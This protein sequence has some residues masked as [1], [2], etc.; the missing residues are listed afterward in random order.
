MRGA[1][2]PRLASEHV[3]P[4]TASPAPATCDR[5]N[6]ADDPEAK[7]A[8][9][10]KLDKLQSAKVQDRMAAE[11]GFLS[12][13]AR[14]VAEDNRR[15]QKALAEAQRCIY[16]LKAQCLALRDRVAHGETDSP[17]P[18][19]Q[20]S[21]TSGAA[22]ATLQARVVAELQAIIQRQGQQLAAL[23]RQSS[24]D[25]GLLEAVPEVHASTGPVDPT[26]QSPLSPLSPLVPLSHTSA[27]WNAAVVPQSSSL[28]SISAHLP[29]ASPHSVDQSVERAGDVSRLRKNDTPVLGSHN[30]DVS[31]PGSPSNTCRWVLDK[32][33]TVR[34]PSSPQGS[35]SD[36]QFI[37]APGSDPAA[38]KTSIARPGPSPSSPHHQGWLDCFDDRGRFFGV[39]RQRWCVL[40]GA[41]LVCY[42]SDRALAPALFLPLRCVAAFH[43]LV[44]RRLHRAATD[45]TAFFF[46]F[47]FQLSPTAP[48]TVLLF[49]A[50]DRREWKQW[51]TVAPAHLPSTASGAGRG[52]DGGEL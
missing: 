34:I 39:F 22:P 52:R 51:C 40:D 47:E 15:L 49:R 30:S 48:R 33:V 24:W 14:S 25:E 13:L 29:R 23:S 32:H 43:P 3:T 42:P 2:T 45:P 9:L 27:S 6:G 38:S 36:L 20:S 17:L 28:N 8:I 1:S 10:S 35:E 46:G 12:D 4:L 41:A 19:G 31:L 37:T 26:P 44:T 5:Q 21:P 16:G 50:R 7:W 18:S 11:V